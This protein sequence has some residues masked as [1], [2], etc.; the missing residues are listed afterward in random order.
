MVMRGSRRLPKQNLQQQMYGLP[1][2]S[3]AQ[4]VTLAVLLAACTGLAWWL[5]L[6]GGT[7]IVSGWFGWRWPAGDPSRRACLAAAFSIY[8]VRVLF[9]E[10]VFLKRGVSWSEVSSIAPWVLFIFVLLSFAGGADGD[11]FGAAA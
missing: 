2:R 8:F 9:T 3:L 11:A 7:A 10:F 5:L 6:G 1:G 4:R